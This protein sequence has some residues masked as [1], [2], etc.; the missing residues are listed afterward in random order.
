MTLKRKPLSNTFPYRVDI[1]FVDEEGEQKT[2][3]FKAIFLRKKRS[4]MDGLWKIKPDEPQDAAGISADEKYRRAL[5]SDADWVMRFTSGWHDVEVDGSTE[6]TRD[7]L[8][9]LLD[10]Y[11]TLAG[12]MFNAFF[13]GNSGGVRKN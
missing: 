3:S 10:E 11:P 4:E 2:H 9:V 8:L 1:R 12:D 5:E 7:N 6:F 13:E